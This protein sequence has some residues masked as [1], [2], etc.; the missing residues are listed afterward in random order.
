[1]NFLDKMKLAV[2]TKAGMTGL[3]IKEKSP[4]IFFVLGVGTMIGAVVTGIRAGRKHD[5]LITDHEDRLAAAKAEYYYPEVPDGDDND[6]E[7]VQEPVQRTQKE[8]R[9]A[10]RHEYGV[11]LLGFAR[12]YSATGL[13]IGV[14]TACFLKM[15]NI[16][17]GRILAAETV[18]TGLREYISQ[19]EKRNIELNG[20]ESH[21]M[22]KYGYKEVEVEEED[23]DNG[24]TYKVKKKVP[25]DADEYIKELHSSTFHDHIYIFDK[26]TSTIYTGRGSQ[27]IATLK[28]VEETI[29]NLVITRGWAVV[30]DALAFLGMPLNDTTGMVEGWI[31]GDVVDFGIDDP[32]NNKALAGYLNES[33]IVDFNV[34]SNVF[35]HNR[36]KEDDEIK[37]RLG[38]QEQ[39]QKEGEEA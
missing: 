16:Q 34:Q 18:T 9:R 1:M 17:A 2:S 32:I 4:E 14:S 37:K 35:A 19:Y 33:I 29:R 15:K 25:L 23:P 39:A 36:R 21:R 20:E 7:M 13:L 30:N 12:L 10:V 3:K 22:C 5:E 11:T 6:E 26:T 38:L 31:R 27:D 24:E 8:I 28:I